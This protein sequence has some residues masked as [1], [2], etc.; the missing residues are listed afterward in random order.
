MNSVFLPI[1]IHFFVDKIAEAYSKSLGVAPILATTN[2]T[3]LK[4]VIIL[5]QKQFT[6]LYE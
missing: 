5:T 3:I 4:A 2:K 1:Q 6:L